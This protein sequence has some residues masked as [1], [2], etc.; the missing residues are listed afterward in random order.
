MIKVGMTGRA[1]IHVR[2]QTL[3][4]RLLRL[5]NDTITFKL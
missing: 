3:G 1:K 5:I 4:E 2:P